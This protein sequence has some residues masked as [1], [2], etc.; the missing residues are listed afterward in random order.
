MERMS[1]ERRARIDKAVRQDLERMLLVELRKLSG[2]TQ[3]QLAKSLG[4]KQP[5]LSQLESQD[6]MQISTLRRIIEALGGELEIIAT[7]P[8]GRIA[9]SQF[10]EPRRKRSA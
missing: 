4:I 1:P 8:T 5:T 9:L 2:M 7:L 10:K 6:D 3:V